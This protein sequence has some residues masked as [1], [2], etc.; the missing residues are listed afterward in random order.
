MTLAKGVAD[1]KALARISTWIETNSI[2]DPQQLT[3]AGLNI[4]YSDDVTLTYAAS[5]LLR[6]D[7]GDTVVWKI[8]VVG[9]RIEARTFAA[10]IA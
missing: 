8:I 10:C 7:G 2:K 5:Y 1:G 6:I 3:L 9:Q 4:E